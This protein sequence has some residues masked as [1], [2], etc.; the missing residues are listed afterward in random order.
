MVG[1]EANMA[2]SDRATISSKI[3]EIGDSFPVGSEEIIVNVG[4]TSISSW[5]KIVEGFSMISY[6]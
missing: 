1:S 3:S 6:F 5:I 2:G 4:V